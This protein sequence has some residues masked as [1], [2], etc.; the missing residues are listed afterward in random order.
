MTA[1]HRIIDSPIGPLT[2]VGEGD[3]LT[4]LYFPGHW[5]RPDASAWGPADDASLTTAAGQLSEYFAGQRTAFAL[6]L[7]LRGTAFQRAVWTRLTAI[8]HGSTTTYR[9]LAVALGRPATAC[10]AA[11]AHSPDT[12]A[13][14]SAR[15]SCSPTKGFRPTRDWIPSEILCI[16]VHQTSS[17]L[18]LDS[19]IRTASR[20]EHV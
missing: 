11:R 9:E 19:L 10:S 1:H 8:P 4:G 7:R 13:A 17:S 6:R 20:C 14:W 2:L 3:V 15:P 16:D 18:T 12:P 5:T